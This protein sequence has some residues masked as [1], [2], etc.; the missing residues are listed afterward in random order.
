MCDVLSLPRSTYCHSLNKSESNRERENKELT[1]KIVEIHRDSK[2]RY[3]AI[4]IHETLKKKGIEISL[5]RVQRLMSEANIRSITKKKFKPYP[6]KEKILER[7]NILK[8]DFST[9]TINEKWGAI[10]PTSTR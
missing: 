2:E 6:S 1:I 4:K 9:T 10:S 3:G 8:Q 5:K 7:D